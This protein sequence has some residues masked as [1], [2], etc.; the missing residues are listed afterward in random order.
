MSEDKSQE[1][2]SWGELASLTHESQLEIFGWCPCGDLSEGEEPPYRDCTNPK[3]ITYDSVC[4]DC[5][6]LITQTTRREPIT[7]C[8]CGGVLTL[9]SE[10]ESN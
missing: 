6:C 4:P 8:S 5:D 7:K 9:V 1:P 10:K 2:M 3:F